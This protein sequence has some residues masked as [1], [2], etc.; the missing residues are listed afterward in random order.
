MRTSQQIRPRREEEREQIPHKKKKKNKVSS[1]VQEKLAVTVLVIML[2]LLS[3]S[4]VL[5]RIVKQNNEEFTKIV[6]SQHSTYDS[7]V[8]P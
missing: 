7:R 6:L 8:L 2:A 1:Y 4:M 3:L 5:Y